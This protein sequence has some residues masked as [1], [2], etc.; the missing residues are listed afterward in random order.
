[1]LYLYNTKPNFPSNTDTELTKI[2]SFPQIFRVFL[3]LLPF[4]L[5]AAFVDFFEVGDFVLVGDC[6]LGTT[7]I[8]VGSAEDAT[9]ASVGATVWSTTGVN[10]HDGLSVG[11]S[12]ESS[13]QQAGQP[14]K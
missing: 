14:L 2:N 13:P 8:I 10:S 5:V 9:G 3:K 6:V 4:S 1:M 11:Q 7:G 12:I